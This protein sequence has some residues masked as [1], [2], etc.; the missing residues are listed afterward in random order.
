MNSGEMAAVTKTKTYVLYPDKFR[1]DATIQGEQV[2]QIYNAGQAWE[3]RPAGVRDMPAQVRD[4]AAASVR[5]DTIPLLI[6]AS[7]GRLSVRALA[8]EKGTDGTLAARARDF[9]AAGRPG[10]AVH[11][12]S[13][14]DR[15]TGV[16]DG[17][18]AGRSGAAT[19]PVRSEEVFSDYRVINSVRVPFQAA[20][21]RDGVTLVKRVLTRV[22]F[23][24]PLGDRDAV[25]EADLRRTK[26][27]GHEDREGHE[28]SVLDVRTAAPKRKGKNSI[29][30]PAPL[31]HALPVSARRCGGGGHPR[32]AR[33]S[34]ASAFAHSAFL[35]LPAGRREILERSHL[36][37]LR[38]RISALERRV[39]TG[40]TALPAE[41][42]PRVISES[43]LPC[44]N[45]SLSS[46]TEPRR[47][48]WSLRF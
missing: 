24:D 15:Q 8:D 37:A 30:R 29:L 13:D 1:V 17:R 42:I 16:L 47:A 38:T 20:V 3:K 4:D 5:R 2:V 6:A 19:R 7:E 45:D 11:R 28:G 39:V 36:L 14:A 27:Q 12:R 34:P 18:A 44:S 26:D 32:V 22:T 46:M 23:N 35:H 21:V 25:R 9:G 48:S 40:M 41:P 33:L 43:R 31:R 10:A